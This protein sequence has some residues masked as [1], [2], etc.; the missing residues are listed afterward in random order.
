MEDVLQYALRYIYSNIP[1]EILQLSFGQQSPMPF[2]MVQSMDDK[3]SQLVLQRRVIPDCNIVSGKIKYIP[4]L[5]SYAELPRPDTLAMTSTMGQFGLY[6]IPEEAREYV[7]ISSVISIG[8]P[9]RNFSGMFPGNNNNPC[10]MVTLNQ[11][12]NEVLESQTMSRTPPMPMPELLGGD[13]VRL[14]PSQFTHIDWV[15]TVKLMFDTHM[16]N[17]TRSA[18]IPFAKLAL[19]A[20]QIYIH[21]DLIVKLDQQFVQGGSEIGAIKEIISGYQDAFDKYEEELLQF[22][23]G[24]TLSSREKAV[25]FSYMV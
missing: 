1:T 10:P 7:P 8:Y 23:G 15:L 12:A 13:L 18:M 14:I 9:V 5:E 16:N 11:M 21:N 3:I 20:T 2:N 25:I 24:A 22:R 19:Y 4:L 6:R 17:M